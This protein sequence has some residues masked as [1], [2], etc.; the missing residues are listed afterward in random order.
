MSTEDKY[1]ITMTYDGNKDFLQMINN[2]LNRLNVDI[3]FSHGSNGP[4]ASKYI[5][6]GNIHTTKVNLCKFRSLKDFVDCVTALMAL[7]PLPATSGGGYR[8]RV[9]V[10]DRMTVVELRGI[11]KAHDIVGH[12]RMTKDELISAIKKTKRR[13]SKNKP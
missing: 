8:G 12:S 9:V 1:G 2:S 7:M 6:T 4:N 10:N 5:Q 3:K 11:A 13:S